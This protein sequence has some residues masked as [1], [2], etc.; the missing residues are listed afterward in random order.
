MTSTD[1]I[2]IE[3]RLEPELQLF[4]TELRRYLEDNWSLATARRGLDQQGPCWT[5]DDWA[6]ACADLGLG[7]IAIP[8]AYGG[9]G[10]SLRE[11][12]I[13]AGEMGRVLYASPWLAS[14]VVA[15]TALD[16]VGDEAVKQEYL[17]RIADGSLIATLG[18]L[19]GAVRV[20]AA[21]LRLKVS[22]SSNG[23]LDGNLRGVID[24]GQA[25]LILLLCPSEGG[26]FILTA[27]E[28]TAVGLSIVPRR[29]LD[30]TRALYD[31]TL[32]SVPV[33]ILGAVSASTF[34]VIWNT[35]TLALCF[36]ML[37][38]AQRCL[39]IS[40]DYLKLREQ[41]GQK[42]AEF[43]ALQHRAA[44]LLTKFICARSLALDACDSAVTGEEKRA[45][46]ASVK[47]LTND[48]ARSIAAETIQFHGGIGFTFEHDAHLYFRRARSSIL[49]LGDDEFLSNRISQAI[50]LGRPAV[51]HHG[52]V[53]QHG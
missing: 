6:K 10:L 34:E 19:E 26:G 41:F 16:L 18:G 5:R 43:Q 25:D 36:E 52:E 14:S 38:A 9:L 8:A 1:P 31:L 44:D 3:T 21:S 28:A 35:A 12:G 11:L 22:S 37:G 30:A 17:P 48:A 4:R 23:V 46:I 42:L 15:A 13:A 2:D 50:G 47:F 7:A 53:A 27:L 29:T 40:V 24:A 49:M 39:E 33:R 20:D 51:P 32:Q 45:L